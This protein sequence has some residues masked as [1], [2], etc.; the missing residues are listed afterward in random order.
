M[1]KQ[2]SLFQSQS[3]MARNLSEQEAG[4]QP[5]KGVKQLKEIMDKGAWINLAW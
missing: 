5:G 4:K 2:L 1:A 3:L